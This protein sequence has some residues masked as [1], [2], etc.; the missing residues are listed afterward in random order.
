MDTD[1]SSTSSIAAKIE[2]LSQAST[3]G[4]PAASSAVATPTAPAAT[5]VTAATPKLKIPAVSLPEVDL[6][7]HLLVLLFSLDRQKYKQVNSE[8]PSLIEIL[9]EKNI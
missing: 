4:N 5:N 9:S 6:Y 3:S 2:P 1:D 7:L 8:I